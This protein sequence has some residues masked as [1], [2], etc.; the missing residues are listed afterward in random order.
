[1]TTQDAVK[2]LQ[3]YVNVPIA[4]LAESSTNPRKT[5]DEERLEE[6]AE[7]IRSKG[8]LSPLLVRRTDDHLEIVS[9]ARRYRAAQRAGLREVPV[10]L[11]VL[12]DAEAL[13]AQIVE[14]LLRSEI[15]PF[16]EA[17]GFRALLDRE[18]A[19]YTVE[20]IAA[21]TGKAASFIAKRLRLLGLVPPVA[22]AFTA[23]HIGIEH[24]L[25]IA[26][27][28]ADVQETALTH[29]FD[30]YYAANDTERSLVPAS[31]LQAW[32]EQNVYLSLKSVPF[33]KDDETLV[34]ELG[35][36]ANCPKRTGFNTLLFSEV[37]E[38][39]CTDAACFNRKLDAQIAQRVARVPNLVMISDNYN[40][41][42]ET[43]ILA[44]RNY[45]EVVTRKSKKGR[46]IRPEEKLCG[47]LTPA[48]HADGMDKGRL[49]KV[50]RDTTCKVHFGERQEQER[51]RLQWKTEKK[52][53]N[54]K[55]NQTLAFRHRLLADVLKRV[56]PQLGTEEL[57]MVAQFVLRSLS[58]ELVCRLAKRHGLQNP[59]DAHDWQM[60]EKTRA[61]YKK[62]DANGLTVLIFEAM[63]I[64]SAGSATENKDDDPL[65]EA[66]YLYKVD[67]RA[68]WAA[69]AKA[70]KQEART[71][72]EP[73]YAKKKS[74]STT[75]APRK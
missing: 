68:M 59:K 30:G 10:R 42:G 4:E 64:G 51:Q 36:C 37:R 62:A 13:E 38:D 58:H 22:E 39:S 17:Q 47:H 49:V 73:N 41:T 27:L 29:C 21:K 3:E 72:T 31:R 5:F 32:I 66:A 74:T 11:A 45:I 12:T 46:G 56:K 71:K 6:L 18:R 57:R 2:S 35:S 20:K 60:A 16:E 52:A 1:M 48:I 26:K 44:R 28:A 53:A 8:V 43:P 54:R 34:P 50:C 69:V 24:A 67:T 15:H 65:A 55:A 19:G 70:E 75:K 33:S 63:L 7:S 9:G 14:N 40:T 61:L 25:L 23:G